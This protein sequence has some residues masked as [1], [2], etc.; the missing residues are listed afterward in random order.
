[1]PVLGTLG[2]A[3]RDAAPALTRALTDEDETVRAAA[4][5]ALDQIND[6]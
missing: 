1:V 3:A 2:L 4:R 5:K 6:P